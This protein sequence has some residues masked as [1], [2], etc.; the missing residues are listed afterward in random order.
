MS[1]TSRNPCE[2]V[3]CTVQGRG[4][5]L[6]LCIVINAWTKAEVHHVLIPLP[7]TYRMRGDTLGRKDADFFITYRVIRFVFLNVLL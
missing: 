3:V 6:S 1:Q 7:N 4:M 2:N 5:S